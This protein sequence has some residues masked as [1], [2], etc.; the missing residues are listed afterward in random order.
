[1]GIGFV[2]IFH[3][4][5]IT[6]CATLI[7]TIISGA[8]YFISKKENK[9]TNSLINFL[10]APIFLYSS[11]FTAITGCIIVSEIKEVDIGIGDSWYI[12]LS[13]NSKLLFIDVLDNASIQKH[14]SCLVYNIE[15]IAKNNE[16]IFGTTKD[17]LQFTYNTISQNTT[18]T[19]ANQKILTEKQLN[20]LIHVK[21]FYYMEHEK[22]ASYALNIVGI[23]ALICGFLSTV[24]LWKLSKFF[25]KKKSGNSNPISNT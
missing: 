17:S 16:L 13:T 6:L 8:S 7:G 11:Y 1:M 20:S 22:I 12:P 5:V 10:Y 4:I 25:L 15:M 9:I 24:I 14:D 18:K 2:L 21:D 3:F 23:I 19:K